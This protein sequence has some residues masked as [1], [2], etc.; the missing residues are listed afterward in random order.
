[1]QKNDI[2]LFQETHLQYLAEKYYSVKKEV[3]HLKKIIRYSI[4]YFALIHANPDNTN[5]YNQLS[6]LSEELNNY[7]ADLNNVINDV[8]Y[9]FDSN[10]MNESDTFLQWIDYHNDNIEYYLFSYRNI[11]KK[12]WQVLEVVVHQD[13]ISRFFTKRYSSKVL[14][15]HTEKHLK[16]LYGAI[17]NMQHDEARDIF[18]YW[19]YANDYKAYKGIGH[20]FAI[21]SF[22]FHDLI[23]S[24]PVIID[25]EVILLAL[26]NRDELKKFVIEKATESSRRIASAINDN[27]KATH[28]EG[29]AES[30]I[31]SNKDWKGFA[32][33]MNIERFLYELLSDIIGINLYGE[34]YIIAF[35]HET[36]SK[37]YGRRYFSSTG[38]YVSPILFIPQLKRDWLILRQMLLSKYKSLFPDDGTFSLCTNIQNNENSL[39]K[40]L[41]IVNKTVSTLISTENNG[42]FFKCPSLQH[43]VAEGKDS[44]IDYYENRIK[45]SRVIKIILHELTGLLMTPHFRQ[46]IDK[47]VADIKPFAEKDLFIKNNLVPKMW[48]IRLK[49]IMKAEKIPHRS[50]LRKLILG[51]NNFDKPFI[52]K[53]KH[54]VNPSGSSNYFGVYNDL[55]FKERSPSIDYAN[56]IRNKSNDNNKQIIWKHALLKYKDTN[57]GQVESK[58]NLKVGVTI[59]I[60]LREGTD[61]DEI[62]NNIDKLAMYLQKEGDTWVDI[63]KSLGPEDIVLSIRMKNLANLWT[64]IEKITA[65]H[66]FILDTYSLISLDEDYVFEDNIMVMSLCRLRDSSK[67]DE[68]VSEVSKIDSYSTLMKRNI[69]QIYDTTGAFDFELWWQMGEDIGDGTKLSMNTIREAMV[70]AN[71]LIGTVDHFLLTD[72][73][74]RK[75]RHQ[76]HKH[77]DNSIVEQI[78]SEVS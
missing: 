66:D 76:S 62:N 23:W 21:Y 11:H 58:N 3:E 41:E 51:N 60:Y 26:Q 49:A 46:Q 22:Y 53:A 9:G 29:D 10:M 18:A 8:T 20:D 13:S 32:S 24:M 12:A 14:N 28:P 50:R 74:I 27:F 55:E 2:E 39:K 56:E 77:K 70:S 67:Y 43:T 47:I 45:Y 38:E 4:E 63:Y 48:E 19:G 72:N 15:D 34:A 17:S 37:D 68:F 78:K 7:C 75:R 69:L 59:L 52:L 31:I 40:Y 16:N 5:I 73:T 54:S 57:R 44:E 65:K 71:E 42:D 64:L 6:G 1:M 30:I 35:F 25:H 61:V 33:P 36:L